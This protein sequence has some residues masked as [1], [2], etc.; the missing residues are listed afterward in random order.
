MVGS[1]RTILHMRK[2]DGLVSLIDDPA[3]SLEGEVSVELVPIGTV[4]EGFILK[5]CVPDGVIPWYFIQKHLCFDRSSQNVRVFPVIEV[6][7]V[8]TGSPT[9]HRIQDIYPNARPQC[10][11][12]PV[13]MIHL[14]WQ[15]SPEKFA[16]Q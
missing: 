10:F 1:V 6:P 4:P 16:Q 14:E 8:V 9:T 12:E 13:Q 3:C 2:C 7:T 11:P 5:Y 15:K